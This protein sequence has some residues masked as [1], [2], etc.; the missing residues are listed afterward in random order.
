MT[1]I[2]GGTALPSGAF[3]GWGRRHHLAVLEGELHCPRPMELRTYRHLKEMPSTPSG[4]L[5]PQI[6]VIDGSS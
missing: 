4:S 1:I 2:T 5:I 3:T 6:P